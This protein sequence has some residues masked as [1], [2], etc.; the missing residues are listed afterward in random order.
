[1]KHLLLLVLRICAAKY[2]RRISSCMPYLWRR[3]LLR[4]VFCWNNTTK[5]I[6]SIFLLKYWRE[7]ELRSSNIQRNH[8]QVLAEILYV[9]RNPQTR[10]Q[11]MCLTGLSLRHLEFCLKYLLKQNMVKLH[12]REK[13]YVTTDEGLR[14]RQMLP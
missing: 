6:N 3:I 13:T 8:L 2:F 5:D 10:I 12:H 4:L 14:I 7:K 1:M 9:C 11:I